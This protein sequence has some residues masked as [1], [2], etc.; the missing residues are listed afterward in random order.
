MRFNWL[1]IKDFMSIES[2]TLPLA[3]RGLVGVLGRNSDTSGAGSNGSGKSALWDALQWGLYGA[4]SRKLDYDAKVI[5]REQKKAEVE[6]ELVSDSGVWRLLRTQSPKGQ[7]LTLWHDGA[8]L[9]GIE[10][11]GTQEKINGLIGMDHQTFVVSI[12]FGQDTFRFA[13]AT[14]KEQ[15][16]ILDRLLGLEVYEKARQQAAAMAKQVSADRLQYSNSLATAKA[17]LEMYRSQIKTSEADLISIRQ[18]ADRRKAEARDAMGTLNIMAGLLP[19]KK[20]ELEKALFT[21]S[22]QRG[23]VNAERASVTA[24]QGQLNAL[25]RKVEDDTARLHVL[26]DKAQ[27]CEAH[28]DKLQKSP[29]CGKCGQAVTPVE[30]AKQVADADADLTTIAS[31]MV[32]IQHRLEDPAEGQKI[33]DLEAKIA[34]L[35]PAAITQR[36]SVLDANHRNKTAELEKLNA[37]ERAIISKKAQ[38]QA[39]LDTPFDDQAAALTKQIDAAK[40]EIE[41]LTGE[42]ENF[43]AMIKT[44]DTTLA[45]IEFWDKAFGPSG[46]RSYILDS[47]VPY[48]TNRAQHYADILLDGSLTISFETQKATKG[49]DLREQFQIKVDNA[50][51]ADGYGGNSAGERQRVDLCV[52]LA[53]HDLARTRAKNPIEL[54][55]FDEAFERVDE[56]GVERVV[57]LLHKESKEWK[58]CFVIT[59]LPALAGLFGQQICI[60]KKG[61]KSTLEQGAGDEGEGA[62][63]GTPDQKLE[64]RVSA[65]K[66]RAQSK[67]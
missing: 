17:R 34:A 8:E 41:K 50:F 6:I 56:A 16:A 20:A 57:R 37:E 26:T 62:D 7:S 23:T 59:H 10:K 46:I 32:D 39:V 64:P 18:T 31:E 29:I 61:G 12:I 44:K 54:M 63:L 22:E 24:L 36:L 4:V 55:V 25:K 58:S 13:Q 14:D 9:T 1:R 30:Q 52:A 2:A 28:I 67:A 45:D 42:I 3:D 65:K 35:F 49:G 51:G 27:R 15:K 48:L 33:A 5:R 60:H 38:Y 19:E 66:L 47:V 21:I 43:D 11:K 40:G 53:L